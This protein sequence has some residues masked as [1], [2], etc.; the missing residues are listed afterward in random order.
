M[1][2]LEAM[3][4]LTTFAVGLGKMELEGGSGREG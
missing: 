1:R 4:A 2:S 3:I